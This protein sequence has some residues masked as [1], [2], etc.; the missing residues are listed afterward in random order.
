MKR[1]SRH[2]LQWFRLHQGKLSSSPKFSRLS[3][4][5]KGILLCLWILAYSNKL[6]VGILPD[7]H[8]IAKFL[9]A[10]WYKNIQRVDNLLE[11]FS[12]YCWLDKFTRN[13]SPDV[14][15]KLHDWE[16]WQF[17]DEPEASD[18]PHHGETF[19][20]D[21]PH[22]GETFPKLSPNFPQVVETVVE[23]KALPR[24]RVQS[25]ER[26]E[27]KAR[28]TSNPI[29]DLE[30][31]INSSPLQSELFENALCQTEDDLHN[32]V[33]KDLLAHLESTW[34]S[35]RK[36]PLKSVCT[37]SD[38][39]ELHRM[40]R[41]VLPA[42]IPVSA[43]LAAWNRFLL[44]PDRFYRKQGNPIR[45]WCN[46]LS[47][48]MAD[49]NVKEVGRQESRSERAYRETMALMLQLE[50]EDKARKAKDGA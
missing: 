19:A 9:G 34:L 1:T 36:F 24:P 26:I 6:D 20:S 15:Y 5:E 23:S 50:A 11:R 45:F 30:T 16:F 41:R 21:F 48:F 44:S 43:L 8:T 10:G 22:H 28:S 27:D 38:Y 29:D 37:K 46:N 14:Y 13:D 18:F 17:C 25:T 12:Q 33:Y 49:D 31:L 40:L 35:E 47:A 7:V 32:S 3:L 39:V 42:M 4:S 2:T